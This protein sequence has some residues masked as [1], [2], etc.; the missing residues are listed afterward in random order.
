MKTYFKYGS[1]LSCFIIAFFLFRGCGKVKTVEVLKETVKIDTVYKEVN[2]D[3]EYILHETVRYE[4][5]EFLVVLHDTLE[6]LNDRIFDTA[7]V[8]SRFFQSK[9]YRDTLHLK[10]AKGYILVEDSVSQNAIQKRFIKERYSIPEIT[11]TVTI[12]K[13]PRTTLYIGTEVNGN[14]EYPIYSVG[15]NG[16]LVLKSGKY[17]G[18]QYSLTKDGSN[19]YGIRFMLP[20]RTRK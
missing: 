16:G 10:N 3:S 2:S 8:L 19:L 18:V 13:P 12:T 14:K 17:W 5:R 20:I 15:I 6:V 4:D 1:I 7:K 11:K 9:F